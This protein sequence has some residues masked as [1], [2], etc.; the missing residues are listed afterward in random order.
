MSAALRSNRSSPKSS[1]HSKSG[2]K[3]EASGLSADLAAYYYDYQNLQV[4][5]FQ[6]GQAQIRNAAQSEIY[7]LD[8]SVRYRLT[9][10]FN[11]S[12]GAA[13]THARYD[14]SRTRL[15]TPIAIPLSLSSQVSLSIAA[16]SG[17]RL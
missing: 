1:M 8:G 4:S 15:T 14:R 5:S 17:R 10:A 16:R 7:G 11:V 12:V 13:Y 6:A 2:Y 9:D 3:Y